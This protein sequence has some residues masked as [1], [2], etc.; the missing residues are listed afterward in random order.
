M[1]GPDDKGEVGPDQRPKRDLRTTSG[2]ASAQMGAE[3]T[4]AK[5]L[6]ANKEWQKEQLDKINPIASQNM[7]PPGLGSSSGRIDKYEEI[8][9]QLERR[10]QQATEHRDRDI[11]AI[12]ARGLTA[13]KA[14][15]GPDNMRQLSVE[16]A[17]GPDGPNDPN[18]PDGPNVFE[19]AKAVVANEQIR[20]NELKNV[21]RWKN[22][23]ELKHAADIA[24]KLSTSSHA[25]GKAQM[26]QIDRI[27][28]KAEAAK[29]QIG[30]HYDLKEESIMDRIPHA[31]TVFNHQ[32]EGIE[33][34]SIEQTAK[35]EISINQ[36][37]ETQ[38]A[39]A[40][41]Q[42]KDA[43]A[44]LLKTTATDFQSKDKERMDAAV[45]KFDEIAQSSKDRIEQ[46]TESEGIEREAV[47][48]NGQTLSNGFNNHSE[49]V[50]INQTQSNGIKEPA[51]NQSPD[52]NEHS[53]GK[54]SHPAIEQRQGPPQTERVQSKSLSQGRKL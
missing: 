22:S 15:N 13:T 7:E 33:K 51:H 44:E 16:P 21:D 40:E 10:N 49:G 54:V 32:N 6:E 28:D 27:G 34:P 5:A 12:R 19:V 25:Q 9:K 18:G 45:T 39:V 4:F 17:K 48:V 30:T 31:R 41:I 36:K 53:M 1:A 20:A 47:R 23:E 46:L 38:R 11:A 43:H 26:D 24:P 42:R 50:E 52:K 3:D 37:Y 35:A 29:R 8:D 14:F 2:T